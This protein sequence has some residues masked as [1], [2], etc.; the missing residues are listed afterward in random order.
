MPSFKAGTGGT[1]GATAAFLGGAVSAHVL[2]ARL[3]DL[4]NVVLAGPAIRAVAAQADRVTLLCG[5]RGRPVAGMLPGVDDVIEFSALWVE[6][7]PPPGTDG[8][9]DDLVQ[10]VRDDHPEEAVIFTSFDQSPLPLALLLRRA[11][12][13]R[14]SAISAEEAGTLLDVR[15]QVDD[16]LHEVDRDLTLAAQAGFHLPPGDE[17]TLDITGVADHNPAADLAPYVVVHPGTARADRSWPA[18]RFAALVDLLVARGHRVVVT[19]SDDEQDLTARVTGRVDDGTAVDLGGQTDVPTFAR[20]LADASV[21]VCGNTGPAHLAAAAGTPVVS[22][23]PV[24]NSA[25]RFHPWGVPN[26]VLEYEVP[27]PACAVGVCLVEGHPSPEVV[28]L[29]DVLQAVD[30]LAGATTHERRTREPAHA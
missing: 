3:D 18:N 9:I 22:L 28:A 23:F 1:E 15:H 7:E 27:C 20:V 11:G 17:G 6:P 5:P 25:A 19:G 14:I 30:E 21:V 29:S 12:V 13:P 24:S 4:G 8:A 2:V 16:D 26:V 10:T